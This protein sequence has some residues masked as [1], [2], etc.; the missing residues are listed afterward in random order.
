VSDSKKP[1]DKFEPVI[2]ATS[3]VA[4]VTWPA[5]IL[6]ILISVI[7]GVAMAYLGL[8]LGMTV[9]A[10]IP[11]AVI[12]M[13]V[14]RRITKNP[15]VLENNIVQTIGSAGESL[16]AGIIFTIPAFF[17]WAANDE[18]AASG[19]IHEVSKTQIFWLSMLGGTLG[20]LLMIPLR[21]YLVNREHGKLR[22]PEG[23]ACAKII[24]AG[25]EGGGKAKMVFFGI[26]LGAVSR[27]N[28]YFRYDTA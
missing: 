18:L 27:S 24:V 16:A 2:P 7:F 22:F 5:V 10:S 8:K 13:A 15:T 25:D 11:A 1:K 6:G 17:I 23:T 28:P 20:I 26:G 12:S 21:K 4:E 9:S 3:N 19:Y 14:L